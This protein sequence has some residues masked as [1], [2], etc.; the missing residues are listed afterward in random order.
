MSFSFPLAFGD[1]DF[2]SNFSNF[3]VSGFLP[4][5]DFEDEDDDD[6]F[7]LARAPIPVPLPKGDNR[8]ETDFASSLCSSS[9][10]NISFGD[11]ETGE[12]EDIEEE[13]E[14]GDSGFLAF[15]A[16]SPFSFVVF[17]LIFF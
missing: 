12:I 16:T 17:F 2:D 1:R 13:D 5:G 6:G 8:G 11:N 4:F 15:P 7:F 3:G 10:A 9:N 14:S